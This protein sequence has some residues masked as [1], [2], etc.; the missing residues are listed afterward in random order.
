MLLND[1]YKLHQSSFNNKL[2][3][4]PLY[5]SIDEFEILLYNFI[6]EELFDFYQT[7]QNFQDFSLQSKL[8]FET[9]VKYEYL[10]TLSTF[11]FQKYTQNKKMSDSQQFMP[12]L[13]DINIDLLTLETFEKSFD[14]TSYYDMEIF[15]NYIFNTSFLFSVSKYNQQLESIDDFQLFSVYFFN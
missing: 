13:N 15:Q 5:R 8:Y 1:Y 7:N 3:S 10:N 12:F 11:L 2:E 4:F 9:L 14:D 6:N